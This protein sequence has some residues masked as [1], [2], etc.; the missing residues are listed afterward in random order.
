MNINKR[1]PFCDTKCP[2]RIISRKNGHIS[3]QTLQVF[4]RHEI[5]W[6]NSGESVASWYFPRNIMV[7]RVC[8]ITASAFFLI[9]PIISQVLYPSRIDFK[10]NY[11]SFFVADKTDMTH[12][13]V[14]RGKLV[15]CN[16]S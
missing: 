8:T 2:S 5:C 15:G 1:L 10:R 11:F 4:L 14:R 12:P 3:T 7:I 13:P 6:I 9:H 16:I